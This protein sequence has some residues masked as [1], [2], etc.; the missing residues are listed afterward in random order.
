MSSAPDRERIAGLAMD[1]TV[2]TIT[3]AIATGISRIAKNLVI[4]LFIF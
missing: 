2:K 4:T 1:V 3:N